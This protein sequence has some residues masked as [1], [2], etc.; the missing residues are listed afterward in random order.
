MVF[1]QLPWVYTQNHSSVV[2]SYFFI[3]VRISYLKST[4]YMFDKNIAPVLHCVGSHGASMEITLNEFLE[5][6]SFISYLLSDS[7]I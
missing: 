3:K 5:M 1:I 4:V 6:F 2:A 7:V